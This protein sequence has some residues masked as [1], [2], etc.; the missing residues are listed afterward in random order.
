MSS[1]P[2]PSQ[3]P[4]QVILPIRIPIIFHG[5]DCLKA[6]RTFREKRIFVVTDKVARK[7]LG[8][9]LNRLLE[10]KEAVIYD[11]TEP[12][13]KDSAINKAAELARGLN[14]EL[15]VGIGGGSVMD[16]AKGVYF[17]HAQPALKLSDINIMNR[18]N[19]ADKAKLVLVP[20]T[21][22]TGS[23]SSAGLVFTDSQTGKKTDLLSFEL[24]PWGIFLDPSLP[25]SMPPK[26]TIASGLDAL[27]QAI[28]ALS[29]PRMNDI[30]K[31]LAL[32]AM[33]VILKT[34]PSVATEGATD[35]AAREK[36]H[37]AA[38]MVG[39]AMGNAGLGIGHACGHAVGGVFDI[40][41]GLIV[42][43]MLPYAIE[44]NKPIMRD[45]Y[46][47]ILEHL[48]ITQVSDPAAQLSSI[49]RQFLGVLK[50]PTAFKDLGIAP[51]VWDKNLDKMAQYAEN[52]AC[53]RTT[54]RPATIEEL[55]RLLQ[56]AY[57]GKP[58]D[59]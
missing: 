12:N 26:V 34:L 38:S 1:I 5:K 53:M 21:S 15:I 46:A 8:E 23:E 43:L 50:T 19:L 29:S 2:I 10:G 25:V 39:I 57:R 36:V 37:Y 18:Y 48:N 31:A 4:A 55:K 33:K 58:V 45:R 35:G 28:E 20:T 49:V 13:P 16:T 52:D 6:I 22:G 41:H 7:L 14:P 42:G 30:L 47:E 27:A 24:V 17:L 44:Y 40:A 56:H 11:E 3:S 51:D 32:N 9:G 59:F 54:P